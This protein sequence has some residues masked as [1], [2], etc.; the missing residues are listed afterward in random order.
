MKITE[1]R[2]RRTIRSVLKEILGQD[3][4]DDFEAAFGAVADRQ[5]ADSS[6]KSK[7]SRLRN[8]NLRKKAKDAEDKDAFFKGMGQ[9]IEKDKFEVKV[10]KREKG[11][12]SNAFYGPMIVGKYDYII[13]FKNKDNMV[14]LGVSYVKKEDRQF[15]LED[16]KSGKL[17]SLAHILDKKGF[18]HLDR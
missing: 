6:Q 9:S 1:R 7:N 18:I 16:F 12:M 5:K 15:D 14:T 11:S 3:S 13:R 4:E 2:L 17:D 10:I 8:L